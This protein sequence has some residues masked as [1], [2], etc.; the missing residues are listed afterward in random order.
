MRC[1]CEP[2]RATGST[3]VKEVKVSKSSYTL[4]VGKSAT[5]K[6]K[7]VLVDKK[8]E[9]SNAHAKQFRYVSSDKKVATVSSNGKITAVGKGSCVVYVY[10][11]NGCA[12]KVK[13]TVK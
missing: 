8:K 2:L 4:K 9:L 6:A 3:N 11:R 13:V 12:K 5:I 1:N 10:A 7:T